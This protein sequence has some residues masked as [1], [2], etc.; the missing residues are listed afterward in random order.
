MNKEKS[1]VQKGE[2]GKGTFLVIIPKTEMTQ[3]K[4]NIEI[5]L[6]TNGEK[7]EDYESAFIGPNQ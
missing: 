6:Y 3:S 7:V 4:F 5:G 1:E 2:V